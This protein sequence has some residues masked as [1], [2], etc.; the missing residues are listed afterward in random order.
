[1]AASCVILGVGGF[2]GPFVMSRM[3]Q[4]IAEMREIDR[5]AGPRSHDAGGGPGRIQPPPAPPRPRL[6]LACPSQSHPERGYAHQ[7]NGFN[8]GGVPLSAPS[9]QCA[10]PL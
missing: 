10:D 8:Q 3:G 4:T 6:S 1:M 7:I 2:Q 9:N 5:R